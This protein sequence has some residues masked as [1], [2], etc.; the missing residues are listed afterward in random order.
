MIC[1]SESGSI[2]DANKFIALMETFTADDY[3]EPQMVY[4]LPSVKPNVE[5][6]SEAD[7]HKAIGAEGMTIAN[8]NGEDLV[9]PFVVSSD[10][11]CVY[12]SNRTVKD[13][14]SAFTVSLEA[15][16]GEGRCV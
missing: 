7:M 12:A 8:A 11:A 15:E 5:P 9:W 13:S 10:G 4:D 1:F 6:S 2:P 3:D 16:A 14:L